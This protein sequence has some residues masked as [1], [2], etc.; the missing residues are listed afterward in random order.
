MTTLR[1]ALD[2]AQGD[3]LIRVQGTVSAIGIDDPWDSTS[4]STREGSASRLPELG[5]S[6]SAFFVRLD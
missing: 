3:R 1:S 5:Q 6:L 4:R 2:S